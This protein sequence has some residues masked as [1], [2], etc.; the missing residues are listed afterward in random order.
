[1]KSPLVHYAEVVGRF[2]AILE[3]CEKPELYPNFDPVPH[4]RVIAEEHVKWST[5]E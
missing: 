3:F 2:L 5:S 1:M 4:M